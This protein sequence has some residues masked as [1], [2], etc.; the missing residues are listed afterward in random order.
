MD[1]RTGHHHIVGE[2]GDK[3]KTREGKPNRKQRHWWKMENKFS[4]QSPW[5]PPLLWTVGGLLW[6]IF[7]WMSFPQEQWNIKR[8]AENLRRGT[9]ACPIKHTR[10]VQGTF[11]APV[12]PRLLKWAQLLTHK[13][14]KTG[15]D[16]QM[17]TDAYRWIQIHTLTEAAAHID[18]IENTEGRTKKNTQHVCNFKH[19]ICCCVHTLDSVL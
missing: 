17:D 16:S 19:I 11:S 8:W 4:L 5:Q 14:T 18:A 10:L 12:L 2:W 1:K 6:V 3:I 7:S 9:V 13:P 15:T